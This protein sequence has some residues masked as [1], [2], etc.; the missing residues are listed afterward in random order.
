MESGEENKVDNKI[1]F[2][3]NIV[4]IRMFIGRFPYKQIHEKLLCLMFIRH[5]ISYFAS[6]FIID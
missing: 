1:N 4:F 6:I 5:L 3:A 2:T